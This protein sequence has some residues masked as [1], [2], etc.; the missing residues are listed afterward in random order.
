MS[1]T[2]SF[3]NELQALESIYGD[4]LRVEG[5]TLTICVHSLQK[6]PSNEEIDAKIDLELTCAENYPEK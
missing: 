4:D 2:N 6:D 3:E 5:N 1:R